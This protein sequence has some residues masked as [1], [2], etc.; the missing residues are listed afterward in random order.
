MATPSEADIATVRR[1]AAEPSEAT[2]DDAALATMIEAHPLEFDEEGAPVAWDLWA[3]AADVW[4]EKTSAL[5]GNF[6]FSAD[7]ASYSRSQAYEQAKKQAAFCASRAA[8]RS[9]AI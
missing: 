9:I 2:Y 7:G 8:A 4:A 1:R 5:A 3:T 6:D